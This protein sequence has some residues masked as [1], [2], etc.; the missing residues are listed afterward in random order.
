MAHQQ[1]TE[2]ANVY[3]VPQPSGFYSVIQIFRPGTTVTLT[4]ATAVG[5]TAFVLSDVSAMSVGD[6]LIIDTDAD[7]DY[8]TISAINSGTLT[9]TTSSAATYAHM[10]GVNAFR[11][12]ALT[13]TAGTP[14]LLLD[15]EIDANTGTSR[16]CYQVARKELQ[17]GG[18]DQATFFL[19]KSYEDNADIQF[20]NWIL[21][22]LQGGIL[23]ADAAAG[24]SSITLTSLFN[25]ANLTTGLDLLNLQAGDPI[26]ISDGT[27]TEIFIASSISGAGPWTVNLSAA[28]GG[29]ST[30]LNTYTAAAGTKVVRLVYQGIIQ[31]RQRTTLRQNPVFQVIASGMFIRYGQV[32]GNSMASQVDGAAL[33]SDVLNSY[34]QT[35]PEII[36]NSEN[37]ATS[38]IPVTVSEQDADVSQIM[39]DILKQEAS[40]V[41]S[42]SNNGLTIKPTALSFQAGSTAAQQVLVDGG[43]A[44]YTVSSSNPSVATATLYGSDAVN[45]TTLSGA[46]VAGARSIAVATTTKTIGVTQTTS[47]TGSLAAGDIV[48]IDGGTASAEYAIIA[49]VSGSTLNLQSALANPHPGGTTVVQYLRVMVTP[50]ATLGTATI[51]ITDAG[52]LTVT[53]TAYNGTAPQSTAGT[54]YSV[55]VDA[56]RQVHHQITPTYGTPTKTIDLT[57]ASN[58][59][60]DWVY[61]LENTDM[62]GSNL[63]NAAIVRGGTDSTGNRI[64][65]IFIEQASRKLLNAW[66]EG[67]LDNSDITDE[68]QLAD[69]AASQL[70]VLAYPMTSATLTLS[71]DGGRTSTQDLLQITGFDDGSSLIA[72]PIEIDRVDDAQTQRT[73]A[74]MTLGVL[75]PNVDAIAAEY[76]SE[77]SIRETYNNQPPNLDGGT[78]IAGLGYTQGAGLNFTIAG[79]TVADAGTQ[80]SVAAFSG[81]APANATVYYGVQIAAGTAT[82]VQ[83]PS[84]Q[85]STLLSGNNVYGVNYR[86]GPPQRF[87]SFAGFA[88]YK[89][90]TSATGVIHAEGVGPFGGVGFT[91]TPPVP[92]GATFTASGVTISAVDS[93]VKRLTNSSADTLIVPMLVAQFT[94]NE[95]TSPD[96]STWATGA[97]LYVR[98]YSAVLNQTDKTT[99]EK[100]QQLGLIHSISNGQQLTLFAKPVTPGQKVDVAVSIKDGQDGETS[101][102]YLGNYTIPQSQFQGG[103]LSK[104]LVIN[105]NNCDGAGTVSPSIFGW[106]NAFASG[107]IQSGGSYTVNGKVYTTL[108][109]PFVASTAGRYEDVP[110]IPGQTYTYCFLAYSDPSA[111]AFLWI[112]ATDNITSFNASPGTPTGSPGTFYSGAISSSVGRS[113]SVGQQ[114]WTCLY[115]TFTVPNNQSTARIRL[116]NSGTAG[117]VYF[118]GVQVIQGT[119]IQDYPHDDAG[120]GHTVL[121]FVSD[122][123][124]YGRVKLTELSSGTVKQLNDGTNVRTAAN[125]AA[126]VGTDNAFPS[127]APF[128]THVPNSLANLVSNITVHTYSSASGSLSMWFTSTTTSSS[129]GGSSYP[130]WQYPDGSGGVY[131]GHTNG[132]AAVCGS[133]SSALPTVNGPWSWTGLGSSGVYVGVKYDVLNDEFSVVY[134]PSSSQPTD[135]QISAAIGDGSVV[136]V[137]ATAATGNAIPTGGGG[138]HTTSGGGG[139]NRY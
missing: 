137:I 103:V 24:S 54:V 99:Y 85:A 11:P 73:T 115:G 76:G 61:T 104:N 43:Q 125:V 39:A 81:T 32:C 117:N 64:R 110:V 96:M 102:V 67:V 5:A 62:D 120:P 23:N 36:V 58:A 123:A 68:Q 124:D 79:G 4:T 3:G 86:G 53:T 10:A 38:S 33:M 21:Y 69:W 30:L 9:V 51:T 45:T 88:I 98:P 19:H 122:G 59:N 44:P 109:M 100:Y 131:P 94:I 132:Y 49:S 97:N 106:V 42:Q 112:G 63:M 7:S 40:Q 13:N 111:Q 101:L 20:G 127:S 90:T 26:V 77:K 138:G 6:L 60:G 114:A 74:S 2:L 27:N 55:W 25:N 65:I 133:S 119:R 31:S 50:G 70:A 72:N 105:G 107:T 80:Y 52:S 57:N 37:L 17:Q 41:A 134:G 29:T 15:T 130:S 113:Q 92:S 95:S 135:A 128:K 93:G 56:L 48:L 14:N 47:A 87:S 22:G 16:G 71:Y 18:I 66:Y 91:N 75:S 126:V 89:I 28:P 34:T 136:V 118:A 129:P 35:V 84:F 82:I 78:V 1:T 8:L 116:S 121:D 12:G 108:Q 46:S 83:M 139:Y